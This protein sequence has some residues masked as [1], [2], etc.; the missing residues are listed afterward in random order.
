[1]NIKTSIYSNTQPYSVPQLNYITK[2]PKLILRPINIVF[3]PNYLTKQVIMNSLTHTTDFTEE[4][5][6]HHHHLQTMFPNHCSFLACVD[7]IW[8]KRAEAACRLNTLTMRQCHLFSPMWSFW[9]TCLPDVFSST[10]FQSL[11]PF[12]GT[13]YVD[14]PGFLKFPQYGKVSNSSQTLLLG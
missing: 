10:Q 9:R 4:K 6:K 11:S 1:M 8:G 12:V 14:I 2:E 5:K 7:G 3:L 13:A